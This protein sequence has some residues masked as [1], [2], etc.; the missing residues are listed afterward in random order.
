MAA[1]EEIPSGN[2]TATTP[3][4]AELRNG[5]TDRD[6]SADRPRRDQHTLIRALVGKQTKLRHVIDRGILDAFHV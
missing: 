5:G 3:V 4:H 6:L 1:D 2:P